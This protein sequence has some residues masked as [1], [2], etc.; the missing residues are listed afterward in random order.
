MRLVITRGG[1]PASAS[2]AILRGIAPN[3]GLN[4]P[5]RFPHV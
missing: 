4:V 1:Q 2:E 3:G 5:D